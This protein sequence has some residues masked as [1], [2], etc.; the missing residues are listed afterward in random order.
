MHRDFVFLRLDMYVQLGQIPLVYLL[1]VAF[2]LGSDFTSPKFIQFSLLS[3]LL[4]NKF[5]HHF[6][7]VSYLLFALGKLLVFCGQGLFCIGEG[8]LICKEGFVVIAL[9]MV[10]E[11]SQ[12]VT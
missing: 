1:R 12:I 4:L 2:L 7:S 5:I 6:L 11:L 3:K 10:V 8:I 9:H